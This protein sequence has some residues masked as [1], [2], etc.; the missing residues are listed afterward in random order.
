[1]TTDTIS[2]E[3]VSELVQG[4]L[5]NNFEFGT[6][7]YMTL[8]YDAV[9][10]QIVPS[11][12][13]STSNYEYA[14]I[15][16][17]VTYD[18]P[19][20]N[21][22]IV[23]GGGSDNDEEDEDDDEDDE[24]YHHIDLL[25]RLKSDGVTNQSTGVA[26]RPGRARATVTIPDKIK[27]TVCDLV[28]QRAPRDGDDEDD[29]ICI[30]ES[31]K[32]FGTVM[33][34]YQELGTTKTV[35][36]VVYALWTQYDTVTRENIGQRLPL[37]L[38]TNRQGGGKMTQIKTSVQLSEALDILLKKTHTQYVFLVEFMLGLRGASSTVM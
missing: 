11:L 5:P 10:D 23:G 25:I 12:S 30:P 9:N 19:R 14:F 21:S 34:S 20:D 28:V 27:A 26:R 3:G 1:M 13:A 36:N 29:E 32:M 31:S 35:G 6:Y 24:T 2:L 18:V 8:F 15:N 17:R 4:H 33:F 22:N 37:Y 7:D 38:K 16:K